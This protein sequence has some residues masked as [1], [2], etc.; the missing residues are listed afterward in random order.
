[1]PGGGAPR[2]VAL[3]DSAALIV[4]DVPSSTYDA[5]PLEPRL[6]DLDWVGEAGAAHHAVVEAIADRHLATVPCR[7]FT[8]F[9]S[10]ATAL[11]TFRHA[12]LALDAVFARVRDREEWVLRIGRP[13][14]ARAERLAAGD[15]SRSGKGFLEAKSQARRETTARAERARIEADATRSALE[16]LAD[17][18]SVRPVDPNGS[19]LVDAAFLVEPSRVDAMKDRLMQVAAQLLKD[20]CPVSLTGPWP[21]YSF[22]AMDVEHDA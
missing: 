14:P 11:A 8:I 20:G 18:T 15:R 19:L 2:I 16:A 9:S 22:A 4:A 7:L 6:G 3:D 17:A 12:R 1:M 13:D 21:P 5:Q 10:E